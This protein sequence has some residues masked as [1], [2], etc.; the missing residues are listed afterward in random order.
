MGEGPE[1]VVPHE[2]AM[3]LG[4]LLPDAHLVGLRPPHGSPDGLVGALEPDTHCPNMGALLSA[5]CQKAK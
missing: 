1:G 3:D 4:A 2:G 5:K